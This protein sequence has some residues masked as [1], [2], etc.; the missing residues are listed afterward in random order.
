MVSCE[1]ES[2][3]VL[4]SCCIKVKAWNLRSGKIGDGRNTMPPEGLLSYLAMVGPPVGLSE[5]LS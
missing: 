4:L 2:E 1:D 3:N 5:I